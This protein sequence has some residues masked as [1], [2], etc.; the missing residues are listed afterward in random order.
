MT[1]I[2]KA[3]QGSTIVRQAK[4]YV[5]TYGDAGLEVWFLSDPL[6]FGREVQKARRDHENNKLDSYTYGKVPTLTDEKYLKTLE[7]AILEAEWWLADPKVAAYK[8]PRGDRKRSIYKAAD[9]VRSRDHNPA[10][11]KTA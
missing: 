10:S 3:A 6:A 8:D 9:L 4:F 1:G 5:A 11:E 2:A 7:A